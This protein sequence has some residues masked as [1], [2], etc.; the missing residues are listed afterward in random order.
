MTSLCPVILAGGGGTRL[1]PLSRD[2]YPKQFLSFDEQHSMLQLTLKRLRG[3]ENR[4]QITRPLAL[5]N[6]EHRFLIEEHAEQ[7]QQGFA[8]IMLEPEGRNTAPALTVAALSVSESD[9]VLLMMPA[10][11]MINDVEAFHCSVETAFELAEQDMLV[12]FGIRPTH[13][14]TGF[15][16]INCS[17]TLDSEGNAY[18]IREF[19]EKPEQAVAEQYVQS[20]DYFWNSGI[21]MMKASVWLAA[22]GD[23]KPQILSAC[24]N[25]YK[26]GAGD[27]V[28]YRL[29]DNSFTACPA[30]SIDYAVMERIGNSDKFSAALV[31]MDAG[32]SDIGSWSAVWDANKKDA[33]NNVLL[34]DVIAF[35]T[36]GCDDMIVVDTTDA[37]LVGDRKK[38]QDVKK[39]IDRLRSDEREE[40]LVHARVYRPWGSYQSLDSGDNFQVK[41]LSVKPGSKLSLQLHH[42]RSEHWVVV[43]GIATV[44]NG[45]ETFKLRENESTYI[46]LGTKHR[47]ENAEKV[48]LEVIEVQSGCYLGEDDIVRFEDDF[49][50]IDDE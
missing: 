36:I 50:R 39:I 47:L 12:T 34:G 15:G 9:P 33:D 4:I 17:S 8:C 24:E 42:Q 43:K 30:D 48:P 28:F 26:R 37:V 21:F 16:Y 5:C 40:R 38:S 46:P 45:E 3:L 10:D 6:E 35:A 29:D 18:Q 22:I 19:V 11:H 49:G 31:E 23:F 20:G 13:P 27:G 7:I 41:R 14:E 44:T 32:W 1:W 2:L 25:A